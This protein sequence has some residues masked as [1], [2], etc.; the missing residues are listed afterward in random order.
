MQEQRLAQENLILKVRT[1]SKLYGTDTI[2]S[3]DDFQGICIFPKEYVYGL[4]KCEHLVLNDKIDGKNVDY[5]CYGLIKFIQLAIAN[6]P[7]ILSI[8]YTPE[9]KIVYNTMFGEELIE[10]RHLFLSKKAYH[11]FKGYA[12]TQRHKILIKNPQANSKRYALIEQ[13]G[14]D[15]KFAMHL[16]RLLYEAIDIFEHEE[17]IYPSLHVEELK[18]IR[19]GV[20]SLETVLAQAIQLEERIDTLY[21]KSLLQWAPDRDAIEKLQ[22]TMLER[23]W[24]L[25]GIR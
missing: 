19:S 13:Y 16:I 14:Y 17:I 21:Q 11:A 8:L 12:H 18:D 9:N 4:S 23:F 25:D 2:E 6:N 7:N 1:G 3:D 10:N 15:T 22:M 5:T 20:Y 24:R